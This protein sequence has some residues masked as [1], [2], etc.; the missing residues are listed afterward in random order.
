MIRMIACIGSNR[1]LG[2]KNGLLFHLPTDMQFFK[3]MTHGCDVIMGR[4]TYESLPGPLQGRTM[5]VASR[6]P[7]DDP[8][9]HQ[10][11]DLD[12][13]L[14]ECQAAPREYWVI[15]GETLYK[16]A[17]DLASDIY[18]TEVK[19][20]RPEADTFFP[21]ITRPFARE[22]VYRGKDGDLAYTIAHYTLDARLPEVKIYSP[23]R[24]KL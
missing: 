8:A 16:Q 10:I 11:D 7:I 2:A 18:L 19:A 13:F 21:E 5:W 3:S 14:R 1:E 17:M 4:K 6:S 22:V 9:V 20:E 15:G 24:I 12:L 23:G